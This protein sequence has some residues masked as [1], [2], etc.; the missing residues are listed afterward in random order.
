ME[1]GRPNVSGR[2]RGKRK[3][4]EKTSGGRES[5]RNKKYSTGSVISPAKRELAGRPAGRKCDEEERAKRLREERIERVEKRGVGGRS[6]QDIMA[7]SF[8]ES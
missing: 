7:Q 3:S 8:F 1:V 4:G 5:R 6:W 2:V